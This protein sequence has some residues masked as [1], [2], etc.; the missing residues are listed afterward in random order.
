MKRGLTGLNDG[1]DAECERKRRI[2]ND[3]KFRGLN[4]SR[5]ELPFPEM[6]ITAGGAILEENMRRSDLTCIHVGCV[7][8]IPS[9]ATEYVVQYLSL[10]LGW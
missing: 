8:D 3:S 1:P 9:G 5:M 2:K 6:G 4:N 10:E 7:L